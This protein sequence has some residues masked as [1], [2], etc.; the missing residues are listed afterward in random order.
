MATTEPVLALMPASHNSGTRQE[1]GMR[2]SCTEGNRPV[3]MVS[4]PSVELS[5]TITS[6]SQP[7]C[8]R[9][10]ACKHSDTVLR[11]F[12]D[13]TTIDRLDLFTSNSL[14]CIVHHAWH[15]W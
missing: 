15:W 9:H 6:V 5:T 1:A 12:W 13:P 2:M 10:S 14:G 4:V 11:A 7:S 3:T 8:C